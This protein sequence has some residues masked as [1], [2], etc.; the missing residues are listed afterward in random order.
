MKVELIN[1]QQHAL[2]ILL[3]TKST[4]LKGETL[5]D[6][7]DM[8]MNEKLEHFEYMKD[9]IK[10]SFEFCTYIFGISGVSR[11]FTQQ[12]ERTRTQCYAE[13]SLRAVDVG[14]AEVYNFGLCN[15][16]DFAAV[17]SLTAYK[18][19]IDSGVP[20][21][22][23][24]GILP[25]NITTNII[26][27]TNLRTLHETAKVRL[28]FRTQGEYQEVFKKMKECIRYVHPWAADMLNVACVDS[29]ICCFPRYTECPI[30]ASTVKVSVHQ[31]LAIKILWEQTNHV[32][33]P[34]AKNGVTI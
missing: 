1:Y 28:C 16:Y 20:I 24:R 23:A 27:G 6:I 17:N 5:E 18:T 7:M 29:G 9:T 19:M 31:K 13:Q 21:Q 8:S 25:L 14:D 2:E 10:S 26:V 34:I 30:Q 11:A 15:D 4:R 22:D 3:L 33:N 12:L 32:A